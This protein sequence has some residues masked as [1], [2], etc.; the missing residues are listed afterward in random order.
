MEFVHHAEHDT[1]HH[2]ECA[3]QLGNNCWSALLVFA[4]A[5]PTY[6]KQRHKIPYRIC[7]ASAPAFTAH[8]LKQ[9]FEDRFKLSCSAF[10]DGLQVANGTNVA[11]RQWCLRLVCY[12]GRGGTCESNVGKIIFSFS[13]PITFVPSPRLAH[14]STDISFE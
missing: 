2:K 11:R 7:F 13:M 10:P 14:T 4:A 1:N 9:L 5:I 6:A 8:R 3:L 12:L